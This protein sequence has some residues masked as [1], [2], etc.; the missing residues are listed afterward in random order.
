MS[1]ENQNNLPAI[2]KKTE[3]KTLVEKYRSTNQLVYVNEEDLN[4]QMMFLPEVVIVNSTPD[5]FHNISGKFMP[6]RHQTDRI[7][8]AAGIVFLENGCG[9]RTE[10]VDGHTVYVGS[11]QAKKRMPDG[12]WKTSSVCEYEFDP[13]K[14]C[15]E[16]NLR[17]KTPKSET[18]QKL[19]L[20]T[21]QKFGRARASTGARLRVIRELT[22]MPT[23][24]EAK[25]LKKSMVFCRIALNTDALLQQPELR[26]TAV[27]LALGAK[28]QI[29][30]PGKQLE[31][32]PK[33]EVSENGEDEEI[34]FDSAPEPEADPKQ[35]EI[36]EGIKYLR[37]LAVIP[38]LHKEARILALGEINRAEHDLDKI[39]EIIGKIEGWLNLPDVIKKHGKFNKAKLMQGV[40]S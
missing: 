21:Y 15:E 5:E 28:E 3:A 31:H 6:K 38:Y 29:C 12:T 8:E 39:D 27:K 22:G 32:K 11:A 9:T 4:T 34:P 35:E 18:D 37:A 14:R 2:P 20:L 40:T 30:G 16:D 23:A 10:Q 33:Y 26:D 36:E 25:D 17:A 19:A 1:K 7:G 13:V 24:I